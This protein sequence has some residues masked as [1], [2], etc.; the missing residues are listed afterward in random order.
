MTPT[1][2]NQEYGISGSLIFEASP[3]GLTRAVISTPLAEGDI[4]LQGAH[5]AHWTPRGQK[6]VLF[7][8]CKSF[9]APGKAI[10]GGIPIIFPWFGGRSDGK[11][12]PAHGFARSVEWSVE[13]TGLVDNGTV[14]IVFGLA[15]DDASRAL[16]FD[17]FTA[18]FTVSIGAEL[19]MALD[20]GNQDDQPLRCEEAL[21][22]YL[23][24][25]DI[26]NV[27]VQGLE[28]TNY[29]DKTDNFVRKVR[30]QEPIA[31]AKETDQVH[32]DTDATCTVSDPTW[33]RKIIVS[34]TGSQSTV[35]WNPWIAKTAGMADMAPDE[36]ERMICVETA[37]AAD[38]TLVIEPGGTHRLTTTISVE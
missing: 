27:S 33:N 35:V 4:Y 31:I 17:A 5:V 9:F 22:T 8:S 13:K 37:N 3:G 19:V 25:S 24:I 20:I 23:A 15:A 18:R 16:G 30:P 28:G 7:M 36:W 21:H 12:G 34:K 26:R 2:L 29:I 10:R 1:E 14:E 38:N 11:P 32:L 6:P